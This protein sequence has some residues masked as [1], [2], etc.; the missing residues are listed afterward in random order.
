MFHTCWVRLKEFG[1]MT[2]SPIDLT[3]FPPKDKEKV[4]VTFL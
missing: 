3:Y 1:S 2:G 4:F